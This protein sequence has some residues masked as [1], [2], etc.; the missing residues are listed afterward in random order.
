MTTNV[1]HA[2]RAHLE[3]A[4]REE[5]AA[6]ASASAAVQASGADSPEAAR[7][8]R[9]AQSAHAR[10]N[11]AANELRTLNAEASRDEAPARG[12]AGVA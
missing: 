6:L 3:D 11:T 8:L 12:P 2:A 10:S 1:L 9:S 5:S 4:L 7:A